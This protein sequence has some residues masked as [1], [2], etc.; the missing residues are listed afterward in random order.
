VTTAA[1]PA[2]PEPE[3]V[4]PAVRRAR[5]ADALVVGDQDTLSSRAGRSVPKVVTGIPGFDAVTMGGL[6]RGRVTVLAGQAG[7]GKTVVAAQFLAEGVRR[8]QPGV[9]VTLE[10]PAA[11]LR[12]NLQTFGWDVAAWEER[13]DLA[14]VDAS[15]LLREDGL[16]AGYEIETLAAQIGQ[17]VDRTGAQRLVL[18]SLNTVLGFEASPAAAR[19]R[20]RRLVGQLRR[21]GLTVVLTV[22]TPD[23][24]GVT[25]SRY[26]IEEFV[27]DSVVLVRHVREGSVRRRTVEV[28]KMRGANHR[29]GEH[30]FTILSGQGVVVLPQAVIQHGQERFPAR[31]PTGNAG[32]DAMTGGGFF[33]GTVALVQG[34]T[35]TGKTLVGTQFLAGGA[36]AGERVLLLAYEEGPGQIFR[37]AAAWG[38]DFVRYQEAGLLTVVAQY[39]EGASLDDHLVEIMSLVARLQPSRIVVDSL[40]SL[41]RVGTVDSFHGFLVGLAGFVRQEGVTTLLTLST[42]AADAPSAGQLATLTDAVVLLRYGDAG[43]EAEVERL[44]TL[45]KIRGTGHDR[46]V[47]RYAIG[48]DGLTILAPGVPAPG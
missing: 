8:G 33:A 48:D 25:L 10:E 22:E 39:P 37:N 43:P 44:L 24:P 15:P 17:A 20:L 1:R 18:D 11:D 12:A 27:A 2:T 45:L 5:A 19:Q 46:R 32:L 9:F 14:F 42:S 34:P 6:P 26:G 28:L 40:S 23:D 4:N 29:S 7:S 36:E 3:N 31:V 38:M 13:G 41:E 16:P 35:G 47:R 21:L 30:A